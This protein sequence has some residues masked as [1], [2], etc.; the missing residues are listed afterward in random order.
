MPVTPPMPKQHYFV[1]RRDFMLCSKEGACITF[2]KGKPTHVPKA[3]HSEVMEKGIMP[4]DEKGQELDLEKAI[5]AAPAEIKVMV[6]PEDAADRAAAILEVL[7]Q[8]VARNKSID[9]G[10]SNQP[11]AE[12]VRLAL[13]W[14]VDQKEVRKVWEDNRRLLLVGKE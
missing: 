12:A 9:F 11:K 7:K 8:L 2:E 4:C 10:A 13:G 3:L 5:A 6:A 14:P 1:S